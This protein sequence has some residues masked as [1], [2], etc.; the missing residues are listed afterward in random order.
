M[1]RYLLSLQTM[2]TATVPSDFVRATNVVHMSACMQLMIQVL[3]CLK[4]LHASG[5]A[6]QNIKPSNVM[7]RLDQHDWIL[8]DLSCAA[9]LG[10]S[11]LTAFRHCSAPSV[12]AVH[13]SM[14][15]AT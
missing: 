12:A 7:R 13:C 10:V 5:Y 8:A 1:N 11:L 15:S 3:R 9:R 14:N 2:H 6:H 4:V